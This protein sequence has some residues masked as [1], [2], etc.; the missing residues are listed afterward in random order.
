MEIKVLDA[1]VIIKWYVDEDYSDLALLIRDRFIN[2][3]LDLMVPSLVYFEVLNGLKYTGDFNKDDLNIVAESLENYGFNI[4]SPKNEIR[5]KMIEIAMN[6]EFTIYDA[7]YVAIAIEKKT[8]LY[9]ADEKIKK[10]LPNELKK[11][12][13]NLSELKKSQ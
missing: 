8:Q 5:S 6:F 13:L 3:D 7:I 4:I 2:R 10:K 9:T 12:I 11:Y 1:N